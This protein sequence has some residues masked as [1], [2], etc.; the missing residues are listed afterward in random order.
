MQL[1]LSKDY[2]VIDPPVHDAHIRGLLL[3]G[4]RDLKILIETVDA[5][6]YCLLLRGVERL[7]ADDFRQGNIILD[8]TIAPIIDSDPNDIAYVYGVEGPDNMFVEKK[9]RQLIQDKKLLVKINPSFG[10]S[11]VCVCNHAEVE[12]GGL[13]E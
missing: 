12:R 3:Y 13:P 4:D 5:G 6:H 1:V 8:V 7:R 11:A 9:V 10:C 2:E